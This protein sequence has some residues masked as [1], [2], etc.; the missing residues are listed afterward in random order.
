[1]RAS[2]TVDV[3]DT[4]SPRLRANN[5]PATVLPRFVTTPGA[6][7]VVVVDEV[8]DG[9]AVVAGTDGA[10]VVDGAMV[11]DVVVVGSGS[12]VI[13]TFTV[14][15]ECVKPVAVKVSH[16]FFSLTEVVASPFDPFAFTTEICP[17]IGL[18]VKL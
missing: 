18:L 17:L 7:V 10:T 14:G 4:T 2:F 9:A 12:W 1:V 11:V 3:R 6:T 13:C 16:P 15:A 8:V 5:V